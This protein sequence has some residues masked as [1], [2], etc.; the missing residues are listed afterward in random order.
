TL[1]SSGV[2]PTPIRG[3]RKDPTSDGAQK[4]RSLIASVASGEAPAFSANAPAP[5]LAPYPIPKPAAVP[6]G[7]MAA[8]TGAIGSIVVPAPRAI[9]ETPRYACGLPFGPGG[10]IRI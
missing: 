9:R 6:I 2:T 3:L 1:T 5:S 10:A 8:V 4:A 7:F